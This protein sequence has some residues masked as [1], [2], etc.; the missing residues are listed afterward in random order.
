[1]FLEE[2][3]EIKNLITATYEIVSFDKVASFNKISF[4]DIYPNFYQNCPQCSYSI[5]FIF[6]FL[7]LLFLC[8]WYHVLASVFSF[9]I[10]CYI[11]DAEMKQRIYIFKMLHTF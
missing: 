8:Y 2:V 1:M 3:F 11:K 4:N 9:V 5:K 6:Q 10:S 7:L